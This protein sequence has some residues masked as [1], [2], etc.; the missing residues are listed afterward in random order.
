MG[1]YLEQNQFQAYIHNCFVFDLEYIG[2]APNLPDCHIWDMAFIHLTTGV[3]FE[4]SIIPEMER[5]PQP[6]SSEFITVTKELLIE[7]NAVDFKTAWSC[8]VEFINKHTM[9]NMP[10]ILVAHNNFKSDKKMIEIDCKRHDIK[11][12]YHWCFFDSLIY[13][14]KQLPKRSS[15]TLNDLYHFFF[16]IDIKNQHF[17]VADAIALRSILF[18]LHLANLS[19]SVY[20]SYFTS[21]QAIKWLGPSC[22]RTLFMY[23]ITSVEQ[24]VNIL[25]ASYALCLQPGITIT[26]FV[27]D[28]LVDKFQ[29]KRGNAASISTSLI[30]KWINGV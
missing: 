19:G 14:R 9:P 30:S 6:F 1:T 10:V 28:Y 20:P 18:K 21:L 7:R 16:E 5:L 29:I 4:I 2:H 23:G 3:T 13:A 24:L 22:E 27:E 25:T 12:P 11:L 17:A 15:Y 8:L 26:S